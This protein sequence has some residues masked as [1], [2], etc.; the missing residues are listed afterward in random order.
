[1]R[2]IGAKS[3]Q[4]FSDFIQA[5]EITVFRRYSCRRTG[6]KR[7]PLPEPLSPTNTLRD[8]RHARSRPFIYCVTLAALCVLAGPAVA[9]NQPRAAQTTAARAETRIEVDEQANV[10]RFFIDGEERAVLD[11]SG[12]HVNGDVNYAGKIKDVGASI[13]VS[14]EGGENEK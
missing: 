12:L 10:I 7:A 5:D 11:A 9:E 14:G 1:M 13:K 2:F 8:Q 4:S 3:L 6:G